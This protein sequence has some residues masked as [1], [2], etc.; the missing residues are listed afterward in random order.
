MPDSFATVRQ[1]VVEVM[2]HRNMSARR[3][4]SETGLDK[5]T[6]LGFLNENRETRL[7]TVLVVCRKLDLDYDKIQLQIYQGQGS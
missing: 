7:G 6:V 1:K 5:G 4:A 2:K 3:L